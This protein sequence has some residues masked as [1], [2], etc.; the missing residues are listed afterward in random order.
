M[1]AVGSC[2]LEVPAP[3]WHSEGLKGQARRL[4]SFLCGVCS[5]IDRQAIPP[6]Q[7]TGR[8]SGVGTEMRRRW[9]SSASLPTAGRA[10][11]H[12]AGGAL[13]LGLGLSL[14]PESCPSAGEISCTLRSV[15]ETFAPWSAAVLELPPLPPEFV[16]FRRLW[17]AGSQVAAEDRG[18]VL[19]RA[20]QNPPEQATPE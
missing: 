8:G 11:I 5:W 6:G 1:V 17:S 3:L 18:E 10:H 16:C 20:F 2:S 7:I 9:L 13:R 15:E 19:S 14:P 4:G 12:S